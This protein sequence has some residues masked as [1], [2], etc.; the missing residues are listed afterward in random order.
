MKSTSVS[1]TSSISIPIDSN[2]G[3]T[4]FKPYS[5]SRSPSMLP[6]FIASFAALAPPILPATLTAL[7]QASPQEEISLEQRLDML[8]ERMEK[9]RVDQHIPGFA[10]AVVKDDEVIFARGFGLADVESKRPV[11]ADTI[12]AIGSSTKAFTATLIGMLQDQGSLSFDDPVTD[13]L[14]YFEL[15]IESSDEQAVVTLRDLL[16]HRTGFT[17]M[18]PL[19]AGGTGSRE[20]ILK[21]ATN[22]EPWTDFRE[23]FNYNNV[24]FL[25][26]GEASGAAADS[27]WDEL[28]RTRIFVPLGMKSSFLSTPEAQKDERL[29][30]GYVWNEDKQ[31]FDHKRMLNLASIAPAGAINSNVLDM[32]QWLR[33]QLAQGEYQGTR[34]IS[35]AA[36]TDTWTSNIEIGNE[37]DYGLGWMLRGKGED[38]VIE[39][40][41]N[42]DGFAAQVAFMPEAGIGYVLLTN[43]SATPL[44]SKSISIVF[45]TLLDDLNEE[46]VS[47]K[48]H[49]KFVGFYEANFG[50]FKD[51]QFEVLIQNGNLSVDVPGQTVYELHVPD[52]EG[53]R[54][55]RLTDT[56]AVSF[57]TDEAGQPILMKMYQS[58]MTFE[59]PREGVEVVTELPLED[60]D[61]L[62]GRYSDPEADINLEVLVQNNRLALD[63]PGQMIFELHLPD[64]EGKRHFRVTDKVAVQFNVDESGVVTSLTM[65]EEGGTREISRVDAHADSTASELPKLDEFFEIYKQSGRAQLLLE[66]GTYRTNGTIRLAQSGIEGTYVYEARQ[67]PP[68]YCLRVDLGKFGQ[69]ELGSDGKR[70][71]TYDPLHGFV[72]HFGD[73]SQQIISE[74]PS[75]AG[76]DWRKAFDTVAV[77]ARKQIEER[78]VLVLECK[79]GDLPTRTMYV[80]ESTG[81]IT[82]MDYKYIAGPVRLPITME[83][84]DYRDEA[85]VPI[86]HK[87]IEENSATGRTIMTLSEIELGVELSSDFHAYKQEAD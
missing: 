41:G 20:L 82:G 59:M 2:Y 58:G 72:E 74:H 23:E 4:A 35:E 53:K 3:V 63:V 6:L 50:P 69:S 83:F 8:V 67:N 76:G 18:T 65:F 73:R 78:A 22:A 87:Q 64:S 11:E 32:A 80:D 86:W 40:G 42:I 39:H 30:L 13:Y 1:K 79:Q 62:V 75:I 21:T 27:S 37:I 68:A 81:H 54:Y 28:I 34:L 71:W 48:S 25:A 51:D 16:C 7:S 19:W 9:E 14:P 49:E 5:P 60:F 31:Q 85:G 12:F 26:A 70:T 47:Q 66:H 46:A 15:A 57:E 45:D 84:H 33:F 38:R 24:M 61:R 55:F 43:V 36:L 52:E 29:A 77:S 17:R 56:I 44:Q 10:L